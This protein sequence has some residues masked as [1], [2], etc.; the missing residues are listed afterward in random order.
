LI[1]CIVSDKSK[2]GVIRGRRVT[3]PQHADGRATEE[4][5]CVQILIYDLKRKGKELHFA[6]FVTLLGEMPYCPPSFFLSSRV[7]LSNISFQ[8]R[9]LFFVLF[10]FFRD[11]GL[12]KN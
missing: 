6:L 1:Y 9:K 2:P 3:G 4:N 10:N 8:N 7:H 5:V 12:P 11:M